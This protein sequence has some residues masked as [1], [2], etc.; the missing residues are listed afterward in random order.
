MSKQTFDLIDFWAIDWEFDED[1]LF[2]AHDYSFRKIGS[3]RKIIESAA[4]Q[5]DHQYEKPGNY[6]IVL[7]VVDIFGNET[8]E[9]FQIMFK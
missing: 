2:R 5:I 7:T 1:K 6:T 3:G 8:S 4:T 9:Y